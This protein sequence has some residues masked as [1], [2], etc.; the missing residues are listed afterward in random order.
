MC[1]YHQYTCKIVT[2]ELRLRNLQHL[3][4]TPWRSLDWLQKYEPAAKSQ[5]KKIHKIW[6]REGYKDAEKF[7]KEEEDAIKRA[8]NLEE[9]KGI[10]IKEDVSLPKAKLIKIVDGKENRGSRVKINGWVHRLRRQGISDFCKFV[11]ISVKFISFSNFDVSVMYADLYEALHFKHL[12]SYTV[13]YCVLL[14]TQAKCCDFFFI[15]CRKS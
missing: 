2:E 9:A 15:L 7:K 11:S 13:Q 10:L 4:K 3:N 1:I 6:M 12:H 14:I 5:L 8:K